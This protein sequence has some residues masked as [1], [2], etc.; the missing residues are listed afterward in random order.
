MII[1]VGVDI[2]KV[3]R[4]EKPLVQLV[5]DSGSRFIANI[6]TL[7]EQ[8]YLKTKGTQSMAG[9]FAA[10][11]AVAKALGTGFCGFWP[12]DI[13]ILH[14]SY[15]KPYVTLHEN[16]KKA[17][18]KLTIARQA[19]GSLLPRGFSIELSISHTTDDAIAFAVMSCA[20]RSLTE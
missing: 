11:E 7:H 9:L 8:E 3:K 20:S 15:G 1:G 10:K 16:A 5:S 14:D 19:N 2:V 6:Y 4:F 13:E 12:R 18:E 17:A